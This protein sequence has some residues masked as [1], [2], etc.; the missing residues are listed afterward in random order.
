MVEKQWNLEFP[1]YFHTHLQAQFKLK[2]FRDKK[3]LNKN[4]LILQQRVSPENK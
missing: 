3:G 2:S 1:T 4:F